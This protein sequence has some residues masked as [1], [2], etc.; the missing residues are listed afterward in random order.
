MALAASLKSTLL[1]SGLIFVANAGAETQNI[2][3]QDMKL[4]Q[5]TL[6]LRGAELFNSTTLTLPVGQSQVVLSNVANNI[7]PQSLSIEIN[8]DDVVIQSINL[9]TDLNK[10]S[11]PTDIQDLKAQIQ[12]L[13]QNINNLNVYVQVN[14]EQLLQLKDQG[15]FG[16][17]E[18]FSLEQSAQ[19]LDFIREQM[20]KIFNQQL[21]Y[22]QQISYLTEK[23]QQLNLQLADKMQNSQNEKKQIIVTLNTKKAVTAEL[24]IAYITPNAAWSPTYDIRSAGM[25]KPITLTYKADVIQNTGIN[26]DNIQ[27]TLSSADPVINITPPQMQPW[28]LS[29]EIDRRMR[30]ME[31]SAPAPAPISEMKKSRA[32]RVNSGMANF[33]TANNNGVN[34]TYQIALPYSLPSRDR[35]RSL[36]IKQTDLTGQ[37]R[38]ITMPK[39]NKNVYLQA[40][41]AD[42][43][44]L[45]LLNGNANIYFA[46]SYVGSYSLGN[47]PINE[48]LDIPLGIDKDIQVSRQVNEKLK[49]SPSFLGSTIEQQESYI[50]KIKNP[51][52]EPIALTVYDQIPVS[53][54][55][56]VIVKDVEFGKG[57]LD[58]QSGKIEWEL[59]VAPKQQ[60]DLP[61]NYT[62]KYPK[63]KNII[64]L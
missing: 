15:F 56:D 25:D 21:D 33:V 54:E 37:Y 49:K 34:L 26:W 9:A 23:L 3:A 8:N 46:N 10:A 32:T 42:W 44:D 52:S 53:Q 31:M 5:A 38:Y 13:E 59:T 64:G 18:T 45:N 57:K 47:Q 12:Q 55:S 6:F 58:Q 20:T 14:D 61:L 7:N 60:I 30:N 11:Y 39:L 27:L 2:I 50:I 16:N 1:I 40:Q 62:L 24:Q 17:Q 36:T 35:G 43:H 4:N 19:K 48:T 28:Y 29:T 22:Q 51:R 63:D 41:I